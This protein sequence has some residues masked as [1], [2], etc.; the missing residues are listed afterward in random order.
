MITKSVNG[1]YFIGF[2]FKI[3]KFTVS[4]T[5]GTIDTSVLIDAINGFIL[6]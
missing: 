6:L 5:V 3:L 1:H 2:N 4:V